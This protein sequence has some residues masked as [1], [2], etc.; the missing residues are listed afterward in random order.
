MQIMAHMV[1]KA[2]LVTHHRDEYAIVTDLKNHFYFSEPNSDEFRTMRGDLVI[3]R[4][5]FPEEF[6][7]GM[8]IGF[9]D[10]LD[11]VLDSYNQ[12]AEL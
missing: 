10:T 1:F 4:S 7:E 12:L 6:Q 11:E 5:Q 8:K 3:T 2:M 9:R